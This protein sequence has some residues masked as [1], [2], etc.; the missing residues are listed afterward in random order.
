MSTTGITLG[1]SF[2]HISELLGSLRQFC[3]LGARYSFFTK[4]EVSRR[5]PKGVGLFR[6]NASVNECN[7]SILQ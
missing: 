6:E 3:V 5:C 4:E 2:R 1:D 7:I